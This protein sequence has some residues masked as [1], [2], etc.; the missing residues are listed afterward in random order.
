MKKTYIVP[1]L[2]VV[3]FQGTGIIASSTAN[4]SGETDPTGSNLG[5]VTGDDGDAWDGAAVKSHTVWD[6]EW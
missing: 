2:L 5:N 6:E 3:S 4:I 1:E